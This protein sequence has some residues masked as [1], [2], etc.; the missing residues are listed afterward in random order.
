[1]PDRFSPA[2]NIQRIFGNP[3][4]SPSR[5]GLSSHQHWNMSGSPELMKTDRTK[6]GCGFVTWSKARTPRSATIHREV[7]MAEIFLKWGANISV[8]SDEGY[9]ILH[10][11]VRHGHETVVKLYIARQ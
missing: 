7:Q 6:G 11:A 1:M 5:P 10:T 2:V 3:S 9:T 8:I 4:T